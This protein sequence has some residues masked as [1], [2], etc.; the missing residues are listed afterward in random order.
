MSF[1]PRFFR[2]VKHDNQ[3]LAP[4]VSAEP[5]A[6]KF[7]AAP[8]IHPQG[9]V[10]CLR[11]NSTIGT[12]HMH[13]DAVEIDDRPDRV[14][15]P[16]APRGHLRVEVGGDL[17]DQRRRH[18]DAIKFFHDFLNIPSG[19]PFGIECENLLVE[20]GQSTLMF[21]DQLGLESAIA[22]ARSRDHDLA[23]IALHGLF[24]TTIA[25]ILRTGFT[26]RVSKRIRDARH[27]RVLSGPRQ[28]FAAEV[29][30]H[31]GIEHA[32]ESRAHHELEEAV[33]LRECRGLRGDLACQLFG[34]AC[35]NR[36]HATVS[37]R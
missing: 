26:R 23:E 25:T 2:S 7:L 34:L 16:G 31:F 11:R 14:E 20:P 13:H 30:V 1:R 3:N 21:E 37:V 36:V 28:L 35:Q 22:I 24:G 19:H 5:E 18:I 29:N 33:Q 6:Q 12:T 10:H 27:Q 8:Y 15:L 32:L 4:S 17:R 9:H